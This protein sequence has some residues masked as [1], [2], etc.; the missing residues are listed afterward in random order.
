MPTALITGISGQDG[1][2]LAELLLEKG[3]RVVGVTRGGDD[4]NAGGLIAHLAG[5]IELLSADLIDTRSIADVVRATRPDE[6]Y[7]LAAQSAAS[8]SWDAPILT[9]DVTALGAAR[10]L[11]AVREEA[12]QARVFQA[13]SSEIFGQPEET[14]QSETTR[15]E[16]VTPYGAAKAYAHWMARAYR[17]RYGLFV[18]AGILF[19]HESPRRDARF[20]TRKITRAVAMIATGLQNEVRLGNLEARRDWGFAGD[21]VEAMWRC[22]QAATADDYVIGTGCSHAVRDFCAAA[23]AAAGLEWERHVVVDPALVRPL[24]PTATIADPTRARERL[25]WT[26]TTRFEALV[27]MMVEADIDRVRR[28]Q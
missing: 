5:K 13:S 15:V 9:G 6:V 18:V 20:V 21:Y 4:Q 28:G 16:P 19:N 24:E 17:E 25:G 7:N 23:F 8:A 22:V 14:P 11:E 12:P 3:Y 2:Y 1:S 26:A 27:A 10:V